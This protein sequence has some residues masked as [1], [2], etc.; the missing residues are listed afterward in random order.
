ME[1]AIQDV[2][3]ASG[4]TSRALRHYG[5]VGLLA[6]SRVGSNGYRY[7]DQAALVRLQRILLLRELGL[8]LAS[9]GRVIDGQQDAAA[10]L[11]THLRL[12][13]AE[14]ERLA[15]QIESVRTTLRKTERGE[16]L[17]AAEA[18]DGFD[19][20]Q[21][22]DEVIERWGQ[23]AYDRS[24]RWWESQSDTK[25]TAHR[26][27]HEDIASDWGAANRSGAPVDGEVAQ[28]IAARHVDWLCESVPPSKGYVANIGDMYVADPRFGNNY[29]QHEPGTAAYVRDA[30]KV[31]AERNL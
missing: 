6:P 14:W 4:T 15:R 24:V 25:K 13:E 20:T 18:F 17:M 1:W 9:I 28:G 2:A 3:R 10:A 27:R 31:Y 19:H 11:R 5:A 23:D 21:Y 22:K 7:Y 12:L 16:Q 8:G 30:L 26:Q 29:D